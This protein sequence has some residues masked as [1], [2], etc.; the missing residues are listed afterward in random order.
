MR[1]FEMSVPR[2]SHTGKKEGGQKS[3]A[4]LWHEGSLVQDASLSLT[5][6]RYGRVVRGA[7]PGFCVA[8]GLG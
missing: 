1:S 8:V 4:A 5:T 6:R 7:E 3:W 2:G